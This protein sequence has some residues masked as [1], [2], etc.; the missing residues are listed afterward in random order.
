MSGTVLDLAHDSSTLARIQP[1]RRRSDRGADH[2]QAVDQPVRS[3]A[4][5]DSGLRNNTLV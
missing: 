3:P 2:A 5:V 1:S 4:S